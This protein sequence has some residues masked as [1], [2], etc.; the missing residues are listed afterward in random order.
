MRSEEFSRVLMIL[1]HL[2]EDSLLRT[3]NGEERKKIL[4]KAGNNWIKL[5]D[6]TQLY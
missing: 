3:R 5:P 6:I 1:V 2:T 4:R